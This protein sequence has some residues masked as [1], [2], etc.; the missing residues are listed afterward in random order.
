MIATIDP[1]VQ[2]SGRQRSNDDEP[3]FEIIDGQ[4]VE[5]LPMSILASRVASNIHAHLALH[6]FGNPVG[7]ALMETL[8][9]LPL[10]ADRNRRPDVAFVS[11]KTIAQPPPQAGSDNAWAV[12]PELIVEVISPNDIAEEVME[13]L[14]EYFEAGV[15][16]VWVV[17]PTQRLIYIYESKRKVCVLGEADALDGGA[18]LPALR[19]AIT[20]L[21]PA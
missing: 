11:A 12:L 5:L 7:E 10:P 15:K 20:S 16:L 13:R 8:F 18:V 14:E 17:Y 2:R 6:L 19:I 9:R 1:A 3:L 21:F 4:R